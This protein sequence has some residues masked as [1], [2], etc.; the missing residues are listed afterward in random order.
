MSKKKSDAVL[1]KLLLLE[2]MLNKIREAHLNKKAYLGEERF[3]FKLLLN[4]IE[5]FKKILI[6]T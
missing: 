4:E 6:V 3:I 1:D 5:T 2:W